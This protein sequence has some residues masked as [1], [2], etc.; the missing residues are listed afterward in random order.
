M[1]PHDKSCD[2]ECYHDA[3]LAGP[4]FLHIVL[5]AKQNG[6]RSLVTIVKGG[7]FFKP[8]FF[9]FPDDPRAW[10]NV[11]EGIMLGPALRLSPILEENE[12]G[13]H[14]SYFPAS[15]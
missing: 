4:I 2:E 3:L 11:E 14:K 8:L 1:E 13:V 9:E 15:R 10:E 12:E 6:K 7:T 5:S